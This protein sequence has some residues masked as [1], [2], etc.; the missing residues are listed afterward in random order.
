[1]YYLGYGNYNQAPPKGFIFSSNDEPRLVRYNADIYPEAI[2]DWILM[3]SKMSW[4]QRKYDDVKTFFSGKKSKTNKLKSISNN[5]NDYKKLEREKI[6]LEEKV[7]IIFISFILISLFIIYYI[8]YKVKLFSTQLE[9][10]KADELFDS[11]TDNGDPFVLLAPLSPDEENLPFRVCV[12]E[13][14]N[15][16]CRYHEEEKYCQNLMESCLESNLEP[17]ICRPNACPFNNYKGCKVVSTCLQQDVLDQYIE[18]L[19]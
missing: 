10:Y 12:G 16:F 13:M 2:Y 3:L 18:A 4:I 5:N 15:E 19:K 9:K 8:L 14:A 6:L 17:K 11:L 7:I 1:L